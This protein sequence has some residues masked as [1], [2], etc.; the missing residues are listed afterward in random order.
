MKDSDLKNKNN[1]RMLPLGS[2]A[3]DGLMKPKKTG[4]SICK[5]KGKTSSQSKQQP[6]C[7][8]KAFFNGAEAARASH[9]GPQ[10]VADPEPV[11]TGGPVK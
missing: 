8:I 5:P 3:N 2:K 4:N 1:G 6:A 11:L 7:S 9:D 10:E